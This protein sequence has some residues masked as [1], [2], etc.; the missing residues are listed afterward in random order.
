MASLAQ[1]LTAWLIAWACITAVLVLLLIYRST[2]SLHEDDQLFLTEGEAQL[3]QEQIE[4]TRKM[5]KITPFVRVFGALS[6]LMILAIA[7]IAVANQITQQ[8]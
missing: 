4:N 1:H 8:P 3:Q 5:E 2:L 6:G 7:I